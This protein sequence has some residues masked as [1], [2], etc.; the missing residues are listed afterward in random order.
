M[1]TD[2][3]DIGLVIEA[4]RI[5]RRMTTKPLFRLKFP[6]ELRR[7]VD[8]A[9]ELRGLKKEEITPE[10]FRDILIEAM[11]DESQQGGKRNARRRGRKTE[12]DSSDSQQV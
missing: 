7:R 9:I 11:N 10:L 3:S 12:I 2:G 6:D 1:T 8:T 4:L 5:A